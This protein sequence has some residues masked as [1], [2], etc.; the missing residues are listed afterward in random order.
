MVGN[1]TETDIQIFQNFTSVVKLQECPVRL[2]QL[3]I[4]GQQQ[5]VTLESS[6]GFHEV[7]GKVSLNPFV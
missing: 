1:L 7:F 4:G 5:E 3:R 6:A 2:K